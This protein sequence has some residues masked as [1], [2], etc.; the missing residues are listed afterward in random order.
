VRIRNQVRAAR[1]AWSKARHVRRRYG[2]PLL[3]QLSEIWRL[4][5]QKVGT[6]DYYL[7]A[8]FDPARFPDFATKRTYGGWRLFDEEFRR[9]SAPNVQ[10]I[11]YHKHILYRI[12]GSF[13]IPV[14]EIHALYSPLPDGFERNRALTTRE[15]LADFLSTTDCLPLFGKPSQASEGFGGRGILRRNDDGTLR[16]VTGED[17]T[18]SALVEDIHAIAAKTGTYMLLEFLRNNDQLRE[19]AGE[20]AASTRVVVLM[21]D[22]EPELFK[23]T[24]LIPAPGS[25]VSNARGLV[26]GACSALVD[27]ETGRLRRILNS[28]GPDLAWITEHPTTGVRLDGV[29]L[30]AWP[31]VTEMVMQAARALSPF[32]M[33]HWDIAQTRRGPVVM[34]MNFIGSVIPLQIHGPP[35]IYTEQYRSFASTQKV[36]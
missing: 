25:H 33:Q 30:E 26:T 11:A 9:Y 10:A 34:E 32:R 16:L 2:V 29:A 24:M 14:P 31:Q 5:S 13:G 22:G 7:Y 35:G 17:V 1:E 21:R 8:L 15:E 36:W 27:L 19:L 12:L 6:S 3:R 28:V 18:I 20:A 4:R 23:A